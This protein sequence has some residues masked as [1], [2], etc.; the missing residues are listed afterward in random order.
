VSIRP[1]TRAQLHELLRTTLADHEG[2]LPAATRRRLCQAFGIS[3]RQMCREVATVTGTGST[4]AGARAPEGWW[5][6]EGGQR[7][8]LTVVA[9]T[10]TVKQAWRRLVGDGTVSVG[11]A[12][13]TRQLDRYLPPAV[14]AGLTGD[15]R[16]DYLYSSIYCSDTVPLR[17]TRWQADAQEVPVWVRGDN[18]ETPFKPYQVTFID[19]AT[20]MV[21]GTVLVPGRPNRF[22]VIAALAMA[23]RGYTA[24]DGTFVGGIPDTIRWDNGGEFLNAEVT[25]ACVRLGIGPRPASPYAGWHKGKIERWHETIQ[26]ELYSELPGASDGPVSFTGQQP[27]RGA[28]DRFLTFSALTTRALEWVRAYNHDR[29][30]S[31][32]GTTPFQAWREDTAPVTV[33]RAEQLHP[34]M[35]KLPRPRTVNKDGISYKGIKFQSPALA[36]YRKRTVTVRVLPHV[37]DTIAVFDGDTFVC[38]AVPAQRL[39]ADDRRRLV[40]ARHADYQQ[41]KAA[42]NRAAALR[43][44]DAVI[45]GLTDPPTPAPRLAPTPGA[46]VADDDALLDAFGDDRP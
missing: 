27:W 32:L 23:I 43:A 36:A 1:E 15:G 7:H 3:A 8:V 13:F 37:Y 45:N 21:T 38:D 17:N 19:D 5:N 33:A 6:D 34:M 40:R 39:S 22:D 2:R 20:R 44:Q 9:A 4:A 29:P 46:L 30:H 28:A 31:A 24:P 42:L 12:Q 16:E 41:M 11:Y 25:D 35:L 10:D 26:N 18:G 14:K